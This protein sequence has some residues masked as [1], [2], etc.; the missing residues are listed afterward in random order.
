MRV[1]VSRRCR[2]AGALAAAVDG[3]GAL[4][5]AVIL[6]AVAGRCARG[7]R[8]IAESAAEACDAFREMG[9]D[10]DCWSSTAGRLISSIIRAST[11][12]TVEGCIVV[13]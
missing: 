13:Q 1:A 2:R 11:M 6:C 12:V 5:A 4:F 8:T 7:N 9:A 10:P 3:R